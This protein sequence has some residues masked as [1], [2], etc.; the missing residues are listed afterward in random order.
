MLFREDRK[1]EVYSFL[2]RNIMPGQGDIEVSWKW[3]CKDLATN[4]FII[5][6]ETKTWGYCSPDFDKLKKDILEGERFADYF[7]SREEE[8]S[9]AYGTPIGVVSCPVTYN[10]VKEGLHSL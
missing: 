10:M 6:T 8:S 9:P 2:G 3:L 4:K 5:I 1:V 7:Y